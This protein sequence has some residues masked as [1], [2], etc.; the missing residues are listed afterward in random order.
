MGKVDA[1]MSDYTSDPTRFAE[2]FNYGIFQGEPIVDP[3]KLTELDSASRKKNAAGRARDVVKLYDNH[4]YIIIIGIENQTKIHYTMPLR[5]MDY[6]LRSY[7]KQKNSITRQHNR[8]RDLRNQDEWLSGFSKTDKLKPVLT[9]VVYYGSKPWDGAKDLH[10]ILDIPEEMKPYQDLIQNYKIQLLEINKI[11]NLDY[12]SDELKRVFGFLKYQ[13]DKTAL[14]M[15]VKQ[16]EELFQNTPREDTEAIKALADSKSLQKLIEKNE[17]EE[18]TNMCKA[19]RDWENES[20]QKGRKIGEKCGE[21]R[22][23]RRGIKKG[24]QQYLTDLVSRKIKKGKTIA[25]IADEL[26][27]DISVIE[28][29]YPAAK[30][31]VKKIA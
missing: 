23:E 30:L 10:G 26:E 31:L 4:T 28:A 25:Q 20:I 13:S 21:K 12:F 14:E 22:G 24:K 6:D 17:D 5:V 8:Q 9:L 29:V 16:N 15:Y 11:D 7:E 3:A 1:T 19:I 27:E 2:I 18:G